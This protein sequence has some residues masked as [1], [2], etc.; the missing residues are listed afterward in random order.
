MR[1]ALAV[2]ALAVLAVLAVLALAVLASRRDAYEGGVEQAI[3][4]GSV[5]RRQGGF[6]WFVSIST[7]Q[8]G[9][10]RGAGVLIAPDIVLSAGHIVDACDDTTSLLV[11]QREPRS[12][13]GKAVHPNYRRPQ[14]PGAPQ[15]D[16]GMIILDRPS[17]Y[18][19]VRLATSEPTPQ[20]LTAIGLGRTATEETPALQEALLRVRPCA[21]TLIEL[22]QPNAT[23]GRVCAGGTKSACH[24]DSG[25]PLFR[26]GAAPAGDLVFGITSGGPSCGKGLPGIFTDVKAF[27]AWIEATKARLRAQL[28]DTYIA[29]ARACQWETR[30]RTG[31]T[32]ACGPRARFDSGANRDSVVDPR[33]AAMQCSPS[34]GC[35]NYVREHLL[36]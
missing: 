12:V 33:V 21:P 3:V 28:L 14:V 19:P 35:A 18:A 36:R 2:F 23:F 30:G 16:I 20:S 4:G 13:G 24:G 1:R 29:H 22:G 9:E 10:Y 7:G 31:N 34:W 17:E 15:Y 5:A 26:K 11:N 8:N 27:A 25:G 6:P 32:Y